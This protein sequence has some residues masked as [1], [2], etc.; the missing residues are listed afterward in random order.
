MLEDET[1][2]LS[3]SG[4]VHDFCLCFENRDCLESMIQ[5]SESLSPC[6]WFISGPPS[7]GDVI[8]GRTESCKKEVA[9]RRCSDP[10]TVAGP[11]PL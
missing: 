6:R 5:I 3:Y 2:T 11:G 1:K 10:E 4:N 7:N 8:K 9:P